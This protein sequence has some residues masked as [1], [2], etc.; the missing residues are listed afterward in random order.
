MRP[1]N[2]LEVPETMYFHFIELSSLSKKVLQWLQLLNEKL[3]SENREKNFF[4]DLKDK[5]NVFY[6]VICN[7]NKN[8]YMLIKNNKLKKFY[9]F[10]TKNHLKPPFYAGLGSKQKH[11]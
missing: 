2:N 9:T 8:I 1:S 7:A 4:V 3:V 5:I 10:L 11:L 6:T